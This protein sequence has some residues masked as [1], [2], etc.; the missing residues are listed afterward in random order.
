MGTVAALFILSG[1]AA[2]IGDLNKYAPTPMRDTEVMPSSSEMKEAKTKVILIKMKNGSV[3]NAREANLAQTL[4]AALLNA[5]SG[6][7]SVEV[8]D[9]EIDS[10]LSSEV[11][12]SELSSEKDI[13]SDDMRIASYAIRGEISSASFSSRYVA[14]DVWY[15]KKGKAHYEP[16]YYVYTAAV[17]GIL[18][19]YEIPSMRILKTIKLYGSDSY[20]EEAR[21][22]KRFDAALIQKAGKSALRSGRRQFK[23]FFAPKGYILR[24]RVDDDEQIF[25]VTLG[26]A[27]GLYHGNDVRIYRKQ[28]IENP[29][30]QEKKIQEIV[31]AK[32]TVSEIIHEH[33]A[34]IIIDEDDV[35]SGY[36][37]RL[38]DY[39]K[40]RH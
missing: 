16:A 35:N 11:K 21:R 12:F 14:E 7:G 40:K 33:N 2:K 29:I 3:R 4:N 13:Y 27:E 5:L 20:S 22:Q 10:Y 38:G 28:Y 6:D 23:N 1:C 24:K 8:I 30:S 32:G 15:D 39:I 37:V 18:N 19:I 9:R 25:E 26:G 17:E 36:E 31:I 34:W